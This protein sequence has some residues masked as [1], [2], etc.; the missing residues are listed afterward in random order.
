MGEWKDEG[1]SY[2]AFGICCQH[3]EAS[4]LDF[5]FVLLDGTVKYQKLVESD[6]GKY[7]FCEVISQYQ[8]HAEAQDVRLMEDDSEARYAAAEKVFI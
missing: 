6:K 7:N 3:G 8:K 4:C 1:F 2:G 5:L